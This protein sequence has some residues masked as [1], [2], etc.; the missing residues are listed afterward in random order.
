MSFMDA[1]TSAVLPHFKEWRLMCGFSGLT[2][3]SGVTITWSCSGTLEKCHNCVSSAAGVSSCGHFDFSPSKTPYETRQSWIRPQPLWF[4]TVWR[5]CVWL[6]RWLTFH[7]RLQGRWQLNQYLHWWCWRENFSHKPEPKGRVS[8]DALFSAEEL[9]SSRRLVGSTFLH[10][11]L[12]ETD[13]LPQNKWSVITC[14]FQTH[15][16]I[17]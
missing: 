13:I 15:F 4:I 16:S 1:F 8:V 10:H 2:G 7:T 5:F 9:Q 11:L 6:R 14:L 12:W 3:H 17:R